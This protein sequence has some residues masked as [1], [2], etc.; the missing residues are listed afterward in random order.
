MSFIFTQLSFCISFR[1]GLLLTSFSELSEDFLMTF[2]WLSH[3]FLIT[4]PGLSQ[5]FLRTFL[6][7]SCEFLRTIWGHFEDFLRTFSGLSQDFLRNSS[8]LS[9]TFLRTFKGL[10]QD[11]LR[12]FLWDGLMT[13]LAVSCSQWGCRMNVSQIQ[14]AWN[15]APTN[16]KEV[17][18]VWPGLWPPFLL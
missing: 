17:E 5:D 14:I 3:D 8:G 13:V 16:A 15:P 2:S 18:N 7:V 9:Q 11:F 10:S 4:F 6:L 12:T 1:H